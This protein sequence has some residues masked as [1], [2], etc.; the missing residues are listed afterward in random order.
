MKPWLIASL[1]LSTLNSFAQESV[2]GL[3]N[4]FSQISKYT[5]GRQSGFEGLQSFSSKEV[6][7]SQF[8]FPDWSEG[9]LITDANET[10]AANYLFLYDKVRQFLF[11][12]PKDST[13]VLQ[14]DKDK[15]HGFYLEHDGKHQFEIASRYDPANKTDFYEVLA[16]KDSGYTL[17]K[18]VKTRFIKFDPNNSANITSVR[19]GNMS[20]EFEDDVSYFISYRHGL[21][22]AIKPKDNSIK[23]VLKNEKGKVNNY[24]SNHSDAERNEDFLIGLIATLNE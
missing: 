2:T 24:L 1:L 5:Y 11:L 19:E 7:G 14:A 20:D 15:I 18:L 9:A 8:Y 6:K 12:K 21:P 17:L 22:Q 16:K 4:E 10:A 13:I 23:K 3:R